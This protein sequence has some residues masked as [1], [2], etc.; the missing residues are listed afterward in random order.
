MNLYDA[1]ALYGTIYAIMK[2]LDIN[3]IEI[4][5]VDLNINNKENLALYITKDVTNK[6]TKFTLKEIKGETNE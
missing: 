3:E 6:T 5:D 4:K 1:G 2:S